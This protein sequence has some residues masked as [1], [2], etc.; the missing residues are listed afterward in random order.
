MGG[1]ITDACAGHLQH[2]C[3][4]EAIT[5]LAQPHLMKVPLGPRGCAS[6]CPDPVPAWVL[7]GMGGMGSPW[8]L[9]GIQQQFSVFSPLPVKFSLSFS[10]GWLLCRA[11]GLMGLRASATLMKTGWGGL[12]RAAWGTRGCPGMSQD[13]VRQLLALHCVAGLG[14]SLHGWRLPSAMLC[15]P[16]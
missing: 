14:A 12:G 5:M 2:G 6:S 9:D 11:G 1:L 4:A 10:P 8:H 13:M 16:G 3:H 7:R 15:A